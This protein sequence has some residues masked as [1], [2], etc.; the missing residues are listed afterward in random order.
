MPSL[1]YSK[2]LFVAL[3][4]LLSLTGPFV[5]GQRALTE[6]P[7]PDPEYQLSKMKTAEGFEIS[8]FASDPM[9][10]KPT[11]MAF[12]AKGRLYVTC[13][14]IYP[15]IKPGV[16]PSDQVVRLE[17]TDGDGVADKRTVFADGLLIPTAVLPTPEG[18]YVT[19]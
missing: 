18:V 19:N 9:I 6:I 1:T 10:A 8:L 3:T 4:G 17:D 11:S 13:T 15:H 2:S 7:N 16:L 12:D 5:H 14:P